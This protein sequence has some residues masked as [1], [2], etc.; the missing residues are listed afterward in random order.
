MI[1]RKGINAVMEDRAGIVEPDAMSDDELEHMIDDLMGEEPNTSVPAVKPE[2]THPVLTGNKYEFIGPS[3]LQ[4]GYVFRQIKALRDVVNVAGRVVVHAGELGGY[5][6]GEKNLSQ[7][8]ASWVAADACVFDNGR[9]EDD[10]Y[11]MSG[12][13]CG[14]AV[15]SGHAMVGMISEYADKDVLHIR[16]SAILPVITGEAVIT[17]D[18][19]VCDCAEI[20]DKVCVDGGI[21]AGHSVLLDN[22]RVS[23]NAIIYGWPT[24]EGNT[25]VCGHARISGS[26]VLMDK[27]IADGYV[28]L[29]DHVCVG[30]AIQFVSTG[31]MQISGSKA[32]GSDKAM[33]VVTDGDLR[34]AERQTVRSE[35]YAR[36]VIA[37][38]DSKQRQNFET[39]AAA[40]VE[41]GCPKGQT[42]IDTLLKA[43]G[44]SGD[45]L[46]DLHVT[47][48][49]AQNQI[50][51]PHRYGVGGI[52][53]I[54][55]SED[56]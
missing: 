42:F 26:A 32:I 5:L 40:I 52:W 13:I 4:D 35:W 37:L 21:V 3:V 1:Q 12:Q 53:D 49:E 16:R 38:N 54:P 33:V 51:H 22:A 47:I 20:Y 28:I 46:E 2:K 56:E 15:V 23:G 6:T 48:A 17:G 10:A 19:R 31:P 11:V 55:E 43:F 25:F 7:T 18:A 14:S 24:L 45:A 27:A 29:K 41:K 8:G 50:D 36:N 39:M 34:K 44:L 30:G 9:V